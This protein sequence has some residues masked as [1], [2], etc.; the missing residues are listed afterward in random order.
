MVKREKKLDQEILA[1]SISHDHRSVSIQGRYAVIEKK[2][3]A[4]YRLLIHE[5]SFTALDS[6]DES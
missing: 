3:T 2:K 1:F 5:V 4:I 6:K